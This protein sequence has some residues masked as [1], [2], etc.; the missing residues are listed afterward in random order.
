MPGDIT[1]SLLGLL[2]NSICPGVWLLRDR[3]FLDTSHTPA[4]HWKWPINCPNANGSAGRTALLT[5]VLSASSRT[6]G[7]VPHTHTHSFCRW[8]RFAVWVWD[9]SRLKWKSW[10]ATL[11]QPTPRSL[12]ERT[13]NHL[14]VSRLQR[15]I[16]VS[17]TEIN[18]HCNCWK[19]THTHTQI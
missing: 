10:K 19:H 9:G 16:L 8:A 2:A 15:D 4:P 1:W 7:A 17:S 12:L 3:A 11:T 18:N 6:V 14:R 13:P 5:T